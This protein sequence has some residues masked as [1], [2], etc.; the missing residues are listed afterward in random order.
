[1]RENELA[2]FLERVRTYDPDQDGGAPLRFGEVAKAFPEQPLSGL[3]QSPRVWMADFSE[4]GYCAYKAWHRGNGTTAIRTVVAAAKLASGEKIHL[5]KVDEEL[6]AARKLPVATPAKLR[7]P[8][9]DVARIPELP[10]LIKV[11]GLVYASKVERAGRSNGNLVITEIKTGNWTLMPDHF[12]Q[13]WGYCL[14]APSAVLRVTDGDF[15]ARGIVWGLSYPR[16]DFGPYPFTETAMRLVLEGMGHFERLY[17]AG[18]TS[19]LQVPLDPRGPSARKC[20]PCAFGHT[21]AWSRALDAD[22]GRVGTATTETSKPSFMVRG[23]AE[24]P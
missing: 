20:A 24:G 19:E 22:V 4:V 7:D 6:K 9:I 17:L 15:R 23:W 21:C 12:L 5:R 13:T 11:G 8:R 2:G 18:R 1:M 16:G 3:A 10:A 14:S